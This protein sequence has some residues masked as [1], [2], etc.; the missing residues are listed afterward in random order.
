MFRLMFLYKVR[1]CL[2]IAIIFKYLLLN[3]SASLPGIDNIV[4]L[5]YIMCLKKTILIPTLLTGDHVYIYITVNVTGSKI[6]LK[7]HYAIRVISPNAIK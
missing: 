1:V 3:V 7:A 6:Y 4:L 5:K 2:A